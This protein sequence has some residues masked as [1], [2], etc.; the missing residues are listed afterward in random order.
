MA[1]YDKAYKAALTGLSAKDTLR[2][3][4]SWKAHSLTTFHASLRSSPVLE[5]PKLGTQVE[6]WKQIVRSTSDL[7][8]ADPSLDGSIAGLHFRIVNRYHVNTE[9]TVTRSG[10]AVYTISFPPASR[11]RWHPS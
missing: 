5:L 11:G 4:S 9:G 2:K 6:N 7:F 8:R 3:T 10:Y 1:R